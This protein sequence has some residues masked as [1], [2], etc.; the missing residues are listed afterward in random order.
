M[1]EGMEKGRTRKSKE[2]K[3]EKR[4]KAGRTKTK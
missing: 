2:N 3:N 1:R 4:T